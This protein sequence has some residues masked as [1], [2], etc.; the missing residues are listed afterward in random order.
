[1]F[2]LK[3]ED[4]TVFEILT[5]DQLKRVFKACGL[6][7]FGTFVTV[8]YATTWV[9]WSWFFIT[10]LITFLTAFIIILEKAKEK[11]KAHGILLMEEGMLMLGA[12]VLVSLVLSEAKIVKMSVW[13]LIGF[14][15]LL[16][17]GFAYIYLWVKQARENATS[18]FL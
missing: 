13:C 4:G 3:R 5:M 18:T 7:F 1:M 9:Q 10:G 15:I 17:I 11:N 6:V 14:I 12:Y 2:K 8:N 16:V